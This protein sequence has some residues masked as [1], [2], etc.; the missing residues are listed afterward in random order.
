M[1]IVSQSDPVDIKTLKYFKMEQYEKIDSKIFKV[2]TK[3]VRKLKCKKDK[4]FNL[5]NKP[6]SQSKC[7]LSCD[8][9]AYMDTCSFVPSRFQSI[10]SKRWLQSNTLSYDTNANEKCEVATEKILTQ[11]NRTAS[12]KVDCLPDCEEI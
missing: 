5:L 9:Q 10:V 1:A 8:I 11:T 7:L 6:D 3:I 2:S 12:C 4:H